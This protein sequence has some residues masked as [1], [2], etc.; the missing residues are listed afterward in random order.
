MNPAPLLLSAQL[1]RTLHRSVCCSPF[2]NTLLLLKFTLHNLSLNPYGVPKPFTIFYLRALPGAIDILPLQGNP[3]PLT[4][5]FLK[6]LTWSSEHSS[7]NDLF[8]TH[9]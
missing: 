6:E 9:Y 2:S 4:Q 1:R 8:T 7:F 5:V 3:F